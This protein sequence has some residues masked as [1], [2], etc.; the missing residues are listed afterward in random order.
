MEVETQS[1]VTE[2]EVKDFETR[3]DKDG[4]KAEYSKFCVQKEISEIEMGLKYLEKIGT[5]VAAN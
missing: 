4:L 3:F 5:H 1:K 2:A